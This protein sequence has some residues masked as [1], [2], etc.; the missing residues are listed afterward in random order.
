D[1]TVDASGFTNYHSNNGRNAIFDVEG[2]NAQLTVADYAGTD[3]SITIEKL[4][5]GILSTT[6][7]TDI[8][9]SLLV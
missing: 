5:T 1:G 4:G 6:V 9:A 8:N 2:A 3:P 7:H